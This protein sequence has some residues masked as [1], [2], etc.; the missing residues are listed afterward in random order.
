MGFL[1]QDPF[2]G[3]QLTCPKVPR[4]FAGWVSREVD[5]VI[6]VKFISNA[7][8]HQVVSYKSDPF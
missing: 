1:S 8:S 6:Q 3:A 2:P 7:V 5:G 4:D